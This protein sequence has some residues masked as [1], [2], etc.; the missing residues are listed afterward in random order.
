MHLL[1]RYSTH[2]RTIWLGSNVRVRGRTSCRTHR[3]PR[4][5]AE[6]LETRE[7]LSGTGLTAQYFSDQNLHNLV[8]TR[9]DATINF[10]WAPNQAPAAGLSHNH[11]SVRWEGYL[12]AP[13]TGLYRFMTRSDDG[14][15]LII[16]G[17]TLINNWTDHPAENNYATLQLT[18]GKRYSIEMDYYQDTGSAVAQ[19]FW[20]PPGHAQELIPTSQLY[21]QAA[22]DTNPPTAVLQA[23]M[24]TVPGGHTYTFQV[25]YRDDVAV[26]GSSL[27]TGNVMVTG[28]NR[29]LQI[30]SLVKV[31]RSGNSGELIATYEIRAPGGTWG[32]SSNGLYQVILR[33]WQVK[34]TSGNYTRG[35]NLGTFY[36]VLDGSDWFDSHLHDPGLASEVRKLDSDGSL[37]RNDML[38][39]FSTV[40]N[41]GVTATEFGDLKTLVDQAS[42]LGMPDYVRDLTA[43]LVYGDPANTANG[44]GNLHVGSS[45]GQLQQLVGLWFLGTYHPA[46]DAGLHY[47]YAAG[48]LF[49]PDGPA[50]TDIVQGQLADCYFL[51]GLGEVANH[52]PGLL[53][54]MF[55][56]NGD[57]TY[58][59]RFYNNG[60]PEYVTVDRYLPV[61]SDG[62]FE[63]ASMGKSS[64]DGSNTLWVALAEKAYA[65]LSASGWSRSSAS[66]AYHA[67]DYGWE[68]VAINQLT[69]HTVTGQGTFDNYATFI[70]LVGAAKSGAMIGLDSKDATTPQVVPDH[71]YVLL[72]YNASTQMFTLYNPWGSTVQ[73][74]WGQLSGNFSS[75]SLNA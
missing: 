14:V 35:G 13:V 15:R 27:H 1:R 33:S 17:Q 64:S 39:I 70:T 32:K 24:V 61:G 50:I 28:P 41:N 20:T 54:S 56:D 9:K 69:G 55:I 42:Y 46:I 58:T 34:D 37:S 59:V 18:A 71:A 26:L 60:V 75:W 7:L 52:E 30:A 11:F 74:S 72:G 3:R 51:A 5:E 68:G 53:R 23:H 38:T 73:L 4:L 57:G 47:V 63:Y 8:L 10:N 29:F 45:G 43:K 67:L 31:D 21:P 12:V 16:N 2:L 22:K 19:L 66:N 44:I 25:I 62:T 6:V 36:V 49:G 65:E 40:E 48:S